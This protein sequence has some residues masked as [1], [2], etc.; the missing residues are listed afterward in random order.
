MDT[1]EA[2]KEKGNTYFKNGLFD[3]ALN[4]YTEGL[5]FDHENHILFSNRSAVYLALGEFEKAL[6]DA[7]KSVEF[8][9]SFAK[10]W[11]RKGVAL[12]ELGRMDEAIEAFYES[13]KFEPNNVTLQ[14]EIQALESFIQR[15]KFEYTPEEL[16]ELPILDNR[17]IAGDYHQMRYITYSQFDTLLRDVSKS[18]LK[19]RCVFTSKLFVSIHEKAA[20][21]RILMKR[22]LEHGLGSEISNWFKPLQRN[23]QIES[24]VQD[25]IKSCLEK[26]Q[27]DQDEDQ[28]I[29]HNSKLIAS[30]VD[31]VFNKYTSDLDTLGVSD[32]HK[33]NFKQGIE[34]IL[35][36]LCWI[37]LRMH[38]ASPKA[39]FFHFE[40][41]EHFESFEG[42]KGIPKFTIYPGYKTNDKIY[43][44]PIVFME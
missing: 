27:T 7:N 11:N 35:V 39:E 42:T 13:L 3:E 41:N 38:Y 17:S 43:L 8:Y 25:L 20:E 14:K 36:D 10:G 4:M 9:P 40:N 31:D 44:N 16:D 29:I 30:L 18:D 12:R 5:K 34:S 26:P 22:S 1:A 33:L 2:C 23:V 15:S 32:K 37:E 19:S 24:V 21:Y 6:D 28:P